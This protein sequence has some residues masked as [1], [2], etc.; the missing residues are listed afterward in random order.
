MSINN[1]PLKWQERKG[2]AG[3][4]WV[5]KREQSGSFPFFSFFLSFPFVFTSLLFF[6]FPFLKNP[7]IVFHFFSFFF[8][9]FFLLPFSLFL[10]FLPSSLLSFSLYPL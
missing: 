7:F 1:P 3:M 8:F 9:I 4:L 10:F 2:K 6:C 5:G